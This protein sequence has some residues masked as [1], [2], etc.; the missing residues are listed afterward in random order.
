VRAIGFVGT[1]L[2]VLCTGTFISTNADGSPRI[3]SPVGRTPVP[4]RAD[5][6]IAAIESANAAGGGSLNL[7]AGCTYTLE[8]AQPGTIDGLPPITAPITINGN[9]AT[10]TRSSNPSA[11]TFRIFEVPSDPGALTIRSLTVSNG[12]TTGP[13]NGAGIFAHDGGSVNVDRSRLTRNVADFRGGGIFND[14]ATLRITDSAISNNIA[15]TGGGIDNEDGELTVSRTLVTDNTVN[16]PSAG[17]GGALFNLLGTVTM[18]DDNVSGNTGDAIVN[19]EHMTI[20]NTAIKANTGRAGAGINNVGDLEV[21][22]SL[23]VQNRTTELGGGG[24]INFRLAGILGTA[25]LVDTIVAG[26]TATTSGGG[27]FVDGGTVELTRSPVTDNHAATAPGGITNQQG[28]VALTASPVTGNTP[29]NCAGSPTPV[30]DCV[31]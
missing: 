22:R 6:L 2:A 13:D 5:A 29:T 24:L 3:A 8:S 4:C 20:R 17:G 19:F 21:I 25:R 31:N 30:P 27:I 28:E 18:S 15:F 9:N 23:L 11:P 10:I 14:K 1:I 26:N 16:D 7:T 12:H